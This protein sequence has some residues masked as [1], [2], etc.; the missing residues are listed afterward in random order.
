MINL[1]KEL[2]W[3]SNNI[4]TKTFKK[5][6]KKVCF[7]FLLIPCF[8]F[9]GLSYCL[10]TLPF[11]L[12]TSPSWTLEILGNPR[13]KKVSRISKRPV[14]N[15]QVYKPFYV[16]LISTQH[17]N[18]KFD[19]RWCLSCCL[20]CFRWWC[21]LL[22]RHQLEGHAWGGGNRSDICIYRSDIVCGS[23]ISLCPL[24]SVLGY[25]VGLPVKIF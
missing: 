13:E 14:L 23:I 21:L 4:A 9:F 12:F 7:I 11:S 19:W 3:V 20:R 15:Y 1:S 18:A 10:F 25:W 17:V 16:R 6:F 2:T 24:M 8:H 22:R 5:T